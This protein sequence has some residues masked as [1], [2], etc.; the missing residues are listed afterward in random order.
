MPSEEET[1]AEHLAAL[2]AT[3]FAGPAGEPE[4]VLVLEDG[5][6]VAGSLAPR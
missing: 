3:L 1:H 4:I 5:R 6:L 2:Q